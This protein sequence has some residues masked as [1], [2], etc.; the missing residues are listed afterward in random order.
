M[1]PPDF[2]LSREAA[3]APGPPATTS[4]KS[5]PPAS[6]PGTGPRFGATM[7]GI[8]PVLPSPSAAQGG[9]APPVSAAT[10]PLPS[11]NK[12]V[13]GVARPGI[14]PLNPGQPKQPPPELGAPVA[15]Q[16][17]WAESPATPSSPPAPARRS[18]FRVSTGAAFAMLGSAILL[19]AAVLTIFLVKGRGSVTARASLDDSGS[20]LVELSCPECPDGTKA[21]T[22]TSQSSFQSGKAK[23]KL[24]SP[25]KIGDN[26]VVVGIERPSR[27]R[28][29]IALAIPIE[30]RVRGSTEELSQP[31]PKLSV[32]AS[33]LPGT[34]VIVD[35]KP[36]SAGAKEPARFDF[37]VESELTG[38]EASVKI[39]ERKV[40]YSVT[41]PDGL[42]HEAHVQIRIGITPLV[43]DAPGD[44]IVVSTKEIVIAGR[45]ASGAALKLG[46]EHVSLDAAGRFVKKQALTKGDN[47][48]VLRSTL[49][50]HAPRLVTLTVRRTDDLKHEIAAFRAAAQ[51]S[52]ADVLRAGEAAVGRAVA[53]E[54]SLFDLRG[55][56]YSSLLL[57]DVKNG[58][59]KRPC[60]AKV[61]YGS[62]T[63]ATKATKLRA[64]G[65][66]VRFVDGPRTGQRI[67]EVRA[68]LLVV[69]GT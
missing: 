46:D 24:S 32:L 47:R 58:C 31:S 61:M 65:K 52:Y 28:E 35:G 66:V 27:G 43:L 36:M 68:N 55:D 49:Q 26:P 44:F 23:L 37:A 4:G 40:P 33:A 39:L 42:K 59:P 48:F 10:S 41:S 16:A 45:T 20:E 3:S 56:G 1:A 12:T 69:G 11:A 53:L 67:P 34:S 9:S 17:P 57:L 5:A 2:T 7:I 64:F 38:S 63:E 25:L 60:L 19:A 30:Y 62:S 29:E 15:V 13:L 50:G 21:W 22:D 14:A 54:G 6:P 18:G 8:A 51:A